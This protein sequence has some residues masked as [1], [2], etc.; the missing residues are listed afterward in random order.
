M[1]TTYQI[2]SLL[3]SGALR[4]VAL[5]SAILAPLATRADIPGPWMPPNNYE[6]FLFKNGYYNGPHGV[7]M[8]SIWYGVP[9]C[10]GIF[11]L[12]WLVCRLRKKRFPNMTVMTSLAVF[13]CFA[14]GFIVVQTKEGVG[15]MNSMF[16]A[17]PPAYSRLV[18][19]PEHRA[20]YDRF[21]IEWYNSNE[22]PPPGPIGV[23]PGR[24]HRC[25]P[26]PEIRDDASPEVKVAVRRFWVRRENLQEATDGVAE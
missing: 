18:D 8:M 15:Q 5:S 23:F 21:C 2:K 3:K 20:E 16:G 10:L 12:T 26:W 13:F 7:L 6:G 24:R 11:A 9:I 14:V 17:V 1:T 25:S 19:T 22:P 4:M